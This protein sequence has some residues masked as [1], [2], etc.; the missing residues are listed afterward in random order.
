MAKIKN[1]VVESAEAAAVEA[2][3]TPRVRKVNITPGVTEDSLSLTVEVIGQEVVEFNIETAELPA[4]LLNQLALRGITSFVHDKTAGAKDVSIIPVLIEN[5]FAAVKDGTIF[6]T[7]R[8]KTDTVELPKFV[9][10]IL[11]R[12]NLNRED[13]AVRQE[14]LNAWTALSD[15]DK[16]A[17][18]QDPL[19]AQIVTKLNSL[20]ADKALAAAGI[21]L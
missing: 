14:A 5:V 16:K 21:T 8:T 19:L 6:N 7:A 1:E 10:A 13:K 12:D 17:V 4:T 20:E 18:R 3:K 2:T 9:E 15:E 11:V